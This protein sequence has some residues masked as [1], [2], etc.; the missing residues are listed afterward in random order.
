MW[1]KIIKL[2]AIF[3]VMLLCATTAVM[4]DSAFEQE[5]V[6]AERNSL[7][8][9]GGYVHDIEVGVDGT[10]WSGLLS[11]N[12]LFNST[13]GITWNAVPA[14]VDV[15]EVADIVLCDGNVF[16]IGGI[17]VFRSQNNGSTWQVLDG[18]IDVSSKL[19]CQD[20]LLM[21]AMR[22]GTIALS[23]DEGET[24]SSSSVSEDVHSYLGLSIG[25]S[26]HLYVLTATATDGV[27]QIY[28]SS[29]GGEN[30]ID[31]EETVSGLGGNVQI[32]ASDTDP[33]FVI[34]KGASEIKYSLDGGATF[35]EMSVS[36]GFYY[37]GE[38]LI[39]G[40]RVYIGLNYTDDLGET[41]GQI[42][43]SAGV[44][45]SVMAIDPNDNNK[46]YANAS[47]GISKTVDGGS[48]WESFL[49]GLNG[50]EVFA[51]AQTSDPNIVYLA[52][53]AGIAKT[54]DFT[55]ANPTWQYPIYE[56]G[57]TA[58]WADPDDTNYVIISDNQKIEYS[59]DGGN[60]WT[61]V[62]TITGQG[63]SFLEY[64]NTLY[65]TYAS[66]DD[67]GVMQSVDNG[68]TWT[69]A[70]LSG[71]PVNSLTYD[72]NG[73]LYVGVG[74]ENNTSSEMLGVYKY[75]DG[76]W[77]QLSGDVS[78]YLISKV[79]NI[80]GVLFATTGTGEVSYIF[81]SSDNGETWEALNETNGLPDHAN[82]H[83]IINDR[84]DSNVIYASTGRP[85]S[86]GYIY[87][88]TDQGDT[89]S[90]YYTGL[91]DEEFTT[92]QISGTTASYSTSLS[93]KVASINSSLGLVSGTSTG[94]YSL[95]SKLKITIKAAKTKIKKTRVKKVNITSYIKDASTKGRISQKKLSKV[96]LYKKFKK[97]GAWK[98]VKKAKTNKQGKV[99]FKVRP[100]KST[101]YKVSWTPQTTNLR[102]TYG[103]SSYNSKRI[104][105][106]VTK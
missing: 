17:S 32:V 52:V 56:C 95:Q 62:Q 77:A 33:E 69:D 3:S 82:Y 18:A 20:G 78:D 60:N 12:G 24:F 6:T 1:R 29:D 47:V 58:V 7:Q 45:G 19:D 55:A 14:S 100:R 72:G 67:G 42:E 25:D 46:I 66:N 92:M 37:D 102:S 27:Y 89:W 73:D 10:V 106:K 11:S 76:S 86:P 50:V 30:W 88:T 68:L 74:H 49:S 26:N 5:Q 85:A 4:A 57:A 38:L 40:D 91:T 23:T 99:V 13:D 54:E 53:Q 31:S 44:G 103:T 65:L 90:L 59:A 39:I 28:Y 87:K 75:S 43:S 81:R 94:I 15:G 22:N 84:V 83:S 16:V 97:N 36:D 35:S 79:I 48:N 21:V 64:N 80:G 98:L 34:A 101:Y 61:E 93:Y 105:I 2:S 71:V 63:T 9:E 104:Y 8:L 51:M 96:R 70:G 41:W